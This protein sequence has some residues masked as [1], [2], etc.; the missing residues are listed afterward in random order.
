MKQDTK[1]RGITPEKAQAMLAEMG[2]TIS[3]DKAA[4]VLNFMRKMATL[5]IDDFNRRK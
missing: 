3:L 1:I 5:E 2:I 4:L